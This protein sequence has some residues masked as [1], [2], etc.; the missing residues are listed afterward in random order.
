M[1]FLIYLVNKKSVN[2]RPTKLKFKL[3]AKLGP[4]AYIAAL[5][6]SLF[7]TDHAA[8]LGYKPDF[9]DQAR[10]YHRT[11][12][13]FN[14]CLNT[15]YLIIRK[16]SDYNSDN[17]STYVADTLKDSGVDPAVIQVLIC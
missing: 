1:F 16:P 9:W 13:F 11:G 8:N 6:I 4:A 5:V 15:K 17:V 10:G 14:F 12:S 3:L 7:F 2:I